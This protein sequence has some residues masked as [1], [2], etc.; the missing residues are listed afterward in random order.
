MNI[1]K[2]WINLL[3]KPIFAVIALLM[4]VIC[5][6]IYFVIPE[7]S[8]K[9]TDG[10]IQFN[11]P[12]SFCTSNNGWKAITDDRKNIY[13]MN[14]KGSLIYA[15]DKKQ[16][17][18][19]NA[20]IIDIAFDSDNNLYCHIAVY[21]ERA[22]LTDS[23]V[24]CEI[25]NN[26]KI[27]REVIRYDYRK[28][29]NPP[30]HKVRIMGLHFLGENLYYLYK[31]DNGISIMEMNP[32]NPQHSGKVFLSDE[33]YSEIMKCHSTPDGDFVVLKNNGEI[34]WVYLNGEYEVLYKATYDIRKDEGIFPYDVFMIDDKLYMLAGQEEL[35][36][37]KWENGAFDML[38]PIK[39]SVKLSEDTDLYNFGLGEYESKLAIHINESLYF[40]DE[41]NKLT[42]Y[43]NGI[44]LP[45]T[46]ELCMC[47]KTFLLDIG[48]ICLVI[49]VILGIG[50]LMKWRLSLLS[51]QMLSTIPIVFVMLCVVIAVMFI[52][53]INL[54]SENIIHETIAI[55]E[56]AAAQFTGEEL[57]IITGYESVDNGQVKDLSNRLRK[58]ID[59]NKSD[60]S[61]NYSISIFIRAKDEKFVCI[62]NSDESNQF[63][64][65][66]FSTDK[67]INENFYEKSNT[68]AAD[69]SYGE[70]KNNL[71]L[72]LITPIYLENG[73]YNAVMLLNASQDSLTGE[74]ISAGKSLLLNIILLGTLLI[75]VITL[76]ANRNVKSLKNAKNVIA[77]IADGDFSIRV[78]KFTKDEVGEICVGVNDMADQLEEYFE[79]KN[80]NEQFYYKFVP[81]KFRE[82]LNKEKFT[83]LELGDAQSEDLSILFCDIRAFSLNSEMMTAKESFDFVNRI[84]GIAGPIIR[85]HNGFVDKY[86]GDAV[87]ALFES[88]DDAVYAGIELYKAIVLNPNAENDFGIPDVKVGIGIHS[89]M[90]R[91]GIV[92][93]E[94]RMSG[95]VISNTVN[96]S[97]RMESLTKR[98]GAGIIISKDTL[99]RMKN[100]DMLST[101]YLGMVQVAGVKEVAG[102]Y[103]VLE[104]LGEEQ[105]QKKE[106]TKLEFRQAIRL[107]HTGDL[108]QSLEIF[109]KLKEIDKEDKA[110]GLY[111]RYIEDMI[112]KGNAEHNIF[113]F[114]NK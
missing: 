49:G 19:E 48:I 72:V 64:V 91:I 35:T 77:K 59:G 111:A 78:D 67:P 25:D 105:R 9:Q 44:S 18:Y 106:K 8:Y 58:F 98:Y 52:S 34:G 51:K 81:E 114:E 100:P 37:Y 60:W 74:L 29:D 46:I 56:I 75:L 26:G 1:I 55:N 3:K 112:S 40:F 80:K 5:L 53:M 33:D 99:E 65:N 47:L 94:E 50:N 97:S 11:N 68:F 61:R 102:L 93:E 113:R 84:Y 30:S 110:L 101:R 32:D 90:A 96:L 41:D 27:V 66:N 89:G 15:L 82:L 71:Q 10:K 22:Y 85:K 2:R 109:N 20:E 17:K 63:M 12:E 28:V 7:Y 86:I 23:E 39:K 87:M 104:C 83:D 88:A 54:S 76:V 45:A 13:C 43:C 36:L 92:G 73:E 24:I 6:V 16:F 79:E 107:Y 38:I 70:E 4:A 103:E 21:N 95:T 108:K 62:A 42:P 69:V 57:E 14:E 31:E